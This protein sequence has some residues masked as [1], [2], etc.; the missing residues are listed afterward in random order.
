MID[1]VIDA[2]EVSA[3]L[4]IAQKLLAVTCY[5]LSC[6][7]VPDMDWHDRLELKGQWLR[8]FCALGPETQLELIDAAHSVIGAPY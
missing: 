2:Q 1:T 8:T 7:L 3:G 5:R 6:T 4:G